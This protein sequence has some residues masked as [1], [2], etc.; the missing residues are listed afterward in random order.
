MRATL[1]CKPSPRFREMTSRCFARRRG[2]R[3]LSGLP[4]SWHTCYGAL[5]SIK[6]GARSV[7]LF[8]SIGF[9]FFF[10]PTTLIAIAV[11][12]SFRSRPLS[13]VVLVLSSAI[14]YAF[15][16]AWH[17][18]LLL[19]MI[20]FNWF[21]AGF[22]L[23]QGYFLV[24][25]VSIN[26]A[27]LLVFKY[28]EFTLTQL[29]VAGFEAPHWTLAFPLA[30][31]FYTFHQ[32]S[33]LVDV[34][35]K[36]ATRPDLLTYTAYVLLF[37][38]LVAGPIVRYSEIAFQLARSVPIFLRGRSFRIGFILLLL[39]LAKKVVIADELAP[40]V[41]SAFANSV[42]LNFFQAWQA[43]INF[44]F[45][46]YFD[47]S[48]YTDMAIGIGFMMGLRLPRNF[49][50]PYSAIDISDFWR[51]WHMTLS[52]FL[53]DYLYKPLGGSRRGPPRTVVN[54]MVVMLLGGLWHGANWTFVVWGGLHGLFLVT[55]RLWSRLFPG[56][57]P[58]WASWLIT[59]AAVSVAWVFFRAPDFVV[60]Q[61]I[62][63][64]MF[65]PSLVSSETFF[66]TAL[67]TMLLAAVCTWA[68]PQA[69][70][71]A[72][73]FH[74]SKRFAFI[75]GVIASVTALKMASSAGHADAFIYFAF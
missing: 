54:L 57:L 55:Q 59:S 1:I 42:G 35:R 19:V 58:R 25:G 40:G 29:R 36:R 21:L 31:S 74:Q 60:A 7:M 71:C 73:K 52:R 22:L 37:P 17:L 6:K 70:A 16:S 50:D 27:V 61:E 4:L 46:I 13:L 8:N 30:I 23:N 45:Q 10:L 24:V 39:G 72:L 47:F 15:Y 2:D 51:R 18:V 44:G 62:V 28:S 14:F 69:R 67:A 43:A 9:L 32:I 20:G 65:V 12:A 75:L 34:S 3:P 64:R 48:G 49:N 26:L 5:S 41:N 56:M 53:R 68:L 33:F 66:P 11:V 63:K 38:Q